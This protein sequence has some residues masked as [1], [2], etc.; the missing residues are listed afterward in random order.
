MVICYDPSDGSI[1]DFETVKKRTK[2]F[3]I[4]LKTSDFT[5]EIT[6]QE[7]YQFTLSCF[8]E[9][10]AGS[11]SVYRNLGSDFSNLQ[12]IFTIFINFG[13]KKVR[14]LYL[15]RIWDYIEEKVFLKYGKI[16]SDLKPPFV[17]IYRHK[18]FFELPEDVS[19][20]ILETTLSL[21]SKMEEKLKK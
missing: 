4:N 11:I 2:N 14:N 20:E 18:G 15:K 12:Q 10:N 3:D 13:E 1:Y 16:L 5:L 8:Y 9:Q 19:A 21:T 6:I 17:I 7:K